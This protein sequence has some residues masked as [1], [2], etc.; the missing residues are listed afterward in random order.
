MDFRADLYAHG[1]TFY[2]TERFVADGHDEALEVARLKVV[3]LGLDH[4]DVY[5]ADGLGGAAYLDTV[6]AER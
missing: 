3:A 2:R 5:E 6:G 4:A 1:G